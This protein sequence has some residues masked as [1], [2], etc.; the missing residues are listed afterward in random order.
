[1]FK[2]LSCF[3]SIWLIAIVAGAA[4]K[5]SGD[6]IVIQ[7]AAGEEEFGKLFSEWAKQWMEVG[8]RGGLKTTLIGGG[9]QG[10]ATDLDRL[11]ELLGKTPEGG[12]PMWLVMIGHGTFDRRQARFNLEGPDFT[13][14]EMDGWLARFS[15]TVVVINAASASA[16][17]MDRLSGPGR[18]VV[19]ATKSGSEVQ[20]T[21]FGGYMAR[22]IN[23][24]EGD[25][26]KDGQ[27]SL[28]EA[29]LLAAKLTEEFYVSEGRLSTEHAL[30]DDNG[31]AKGTRSEFFKG[32]R[33]VKKPK[34]GLSLDGGR[35]H[36]LHV[37][38]GEFEQSMPAELRQKRDALEREV[39]VLRE[40]KNK[41]PE[42]DYYDQLENLMLRIGAIYGEAEAMMKKKAN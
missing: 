7:G 42:K 23:S 17:F 37:V 9:K 38:L 10:E 6:L 40:K 34:G 8:E 11:K 28:L 35:A 41:L 32:V 14:T 19:T 24:D 2:T 21:R 4:E 22:A 13:A 15:R 33:A 1:M 12:E 30:M 29:F 26:D 5:K 31:D 20:F 16:P 36:Q 27:V 25:L 18:V 3:L 39:F